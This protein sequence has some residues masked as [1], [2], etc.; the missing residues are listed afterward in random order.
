[1]PTLV[2]LPPEGGGGLPANSSIEPSSTGCLGFGCSSTDLA[3]TTEAQN[4]GRDPRKRSAPDACGMVMTSPAPMIFGS[5]MLGFAACSAATD[6]PNR[7][8]MLASVSPILMVYCVPGKQRQVRCTASTGP[9]VQACA[10]ATHLQATAQLA[11][12]LHLT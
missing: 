3:H 10:K 8:A 9:T 11:E 12:A 4:L 5:V 2:E 6:V 7:L 1:L